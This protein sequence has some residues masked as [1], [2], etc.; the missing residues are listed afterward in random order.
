MFTFMLR[1]FD[2]TRNLVERIQIK[3]YILINKLFT[4]TYE[5]NVS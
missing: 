2:R 4:N 5:I 3:N 1:K